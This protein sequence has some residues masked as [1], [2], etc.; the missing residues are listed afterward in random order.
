MSNYF[1]TMMKELGLENKD[2]V[3]ASTEQLTF[4]VVQKARKGKPISLK[5][6]EKIIRAIKAARPDESFD[7][8]EL[9]GT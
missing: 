5:A 8:K 4:K 9:F 7:P 2:L 6:Q 1:D 3:G